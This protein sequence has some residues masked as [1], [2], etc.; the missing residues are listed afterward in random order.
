LVITHSDY[1]SIPALLERLMKNM[2][3]ILAG[4]GQTTE[5][6]KLQRWAC[7][8]RLGFCAAER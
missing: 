8:P 2:P 5:R 6:K 1:G 4:G 3:P 7:A